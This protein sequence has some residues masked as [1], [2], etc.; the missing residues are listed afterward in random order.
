MSF[1]K[2][3]SLMKIFQFGRASAFFLVDFGK[4]LRS[5]L[6]VPAPAILKIIGVRSLRNDICVPSCPSNCGHLEYYSCQTVKMFLSF[7]IQKCIFSDHDNML[8]VQV[9]FVTRITNIE[10]KMLFMVDLLEVSLGREHL[11]I[12]LILDTLD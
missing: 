2:R 10:K 8:T 12:G 11:K 4:L 5:C 3:M 6:I 1:P 7:S 9:S